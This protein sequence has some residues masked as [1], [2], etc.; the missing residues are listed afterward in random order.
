[1]VENN[2]KLLK[3]IELNTRNSSSNVD[4]SGIENRLSVLENKVD[5]DTIY[6]DTAIKTA[7]GYENIDVEND[8][9]LNSRITLLESAGSNN[10]SEELAQI[11][12]VLRNRV[13]LKLSIDV[14]IPGFQKKWLLKDDDDNIIAESNNNGYLEIEVSNEWRGYFY[15]IDTEGNA[16]NPTVPTF[17]LYKDEYGSVNF[18]LLDA[19]GLN[20]TNL[21]LLHTIQAS[22]EVI[23]D[24]INDISPE[25]FTTTDIQISEL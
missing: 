7:I 18:T 22:G 10:N 11:K 15:I 4:L 8:G 13:L 6:D 9:D 25:D 1:M 5:N 2:N 21:S 24:D 14:Q 17:I 3:K 16:N 19:N 12:R 20:E 23:C